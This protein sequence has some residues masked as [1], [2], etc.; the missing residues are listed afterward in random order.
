MMIHRFHYDSLLCVCV[1]V[2][3]F[4]CVC[5]CAQE[6]LNYI[7]RKEF[8]P[9]LKVDQLNLEREK[10]KVFLRFGQY[11]RLSVHLSVSIPLLGCCA[12]HRSLFPPALCASSYFLSTSCL[13]PA[14]QFV[15]QQ[16]SSSSHMT[17]QNQNKQCSDTLLGCSLECKRVFSRWLLCNPAVEEEISYPPTYRYERGSRDT[18]VWQKQKATGVGPQHTHT[19]TH[20]H[21]WLVAGVMNSVWG[22]LS[23]TAVWSPRAGMDLSASH[24]VTVL[25]LLLSC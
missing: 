15:K 16:G 9:L 12:T 6:I 10:N 14:W 21:R 2:C 20:S 3:V 8:D 4:V 7:N 18:Y 11:T 1:C 13:T 25:S 22:L 23:F 19:H 5:A 17:N 24:Y